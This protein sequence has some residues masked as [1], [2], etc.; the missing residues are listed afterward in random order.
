MRFFF[1][2]KKLCLSRVAV[3]KKNNNVDNMNIR[4]CNNNN[5]SDDNNNDGGSG[6]GGSDGGVVDNDALSGNDN[7][8]DDD[9]GDDTD[10]Q[11]HGDVHAR[12]QRS[13]NA[14]EILFPVEILRV[15]ADH[16]YRAGWTSTADTMLSLNKETKH[17]CE[18]MVIRQ[19]LHRRR[20]AV[21]R[22]LYRLFRFQLSMYAFGLG[23]NDRYHWELTAHEQ[24]MAKYEKSLRLDIP[25][26]EHAPL[27]A[28]LLWVSHPRESIGEGAAFVMPE[29]QVLK[30][31]R[32]L[33]FLDRCKYESETIR[34]D[35]CVATVLEHCAYWKDIVQKARCG[36]AGEETKESVKIDIR[37]CGLSYNPQS[38]MGIHRIS[39]F[40]RSIKLMNQTA[41]IPFANL[42][43]PNPPPPAAATTTS[44]ST[45]T[46]ADTLKSLSPLQPSSP[47]SKPGRASISND[48]REIP[49]IILVNIYNNP[50]NDI[51]YDI[52]APC[53]H[54]HANV[55]HKS[56]PPYWY[57]G[58]IPMYRLLDRMD[59]WKKANNVPL[60]AGY[61]KSIKTCIGPEMMM[62][63][64]AE[65][66]SHVHFRG[67][68]F[69]ELA[70]SRAPEYWPWDAPLLFEH[71]SLLCKVGLATDGSLAVQ[72]YVSLFV[73]PRD[74]ALLKETELGFWEPDPMIAHHRRHWH[75]RDLHHRAT[76]LIPPSPSLSSP[77][78]PSSSSS[79][80]PSRSRCTARLNETVAYPASLELVNFDMFSPPPWVSEPPKEDTIE[81]SV[82]YSMMCNYLEQHQD[83]CIGKDVR[84]C[85]F[86]EGLRS[87]APKH[88][89][90]P[91]ER[92]RD[93][94]S[95]PTPQMR[96]NEGRKKENRRR[97][98]NNELLPWMPRSKDV[99][100]SIRRAQTVIDQ[101]NVA[102]AIPSEAFPENPH[103]YMDFSSDSDSLGISDSGDNSDRD[104]E[105]DNNGD[106][107]GSSSRDCDEND[108]GDDI[109]DGGDDDNNNS[110]DAA[111]S[112]ANESRKCDASLEKEEEETADEISCATNGDSL[113]TDERDSSLTGDGN[114][115]TAVRKD[116][117]GRD[118]ST[119]GSVSDKDNDTVC[120]EYDDSIGDGGDSSCDG[121]DNDDDNDDYNDAK[122]NDANID[123]DINPDSDLD[124][125]MLCVCSE[126]EDE[127]EP[128]VTVFGIRRDIPLQPPERW[129]LS[130]SARQAMTASGNP[131][132]RIRK[133]KSTACIVSQ[134]R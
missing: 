42:P 131:Y 48:N 8:D 26:M 102:T 38:F 43:T 80:S 71:V 14:C 58:P 87:R 60:L 34:G 84:I 10:D 2:K 74:L 17:E 110:L 55:H 21:H 9:D 11:H 53:C 25:S 39:P 52:A 7:H 78:S 108:K 61:E 111:R 51:E 77:S 133:G 40:S 28:L 6:H 93:T 95:S 16:L 65:L 4:N 23:Y 50:Q 75:Y 120:H 90:K 57:V 105:G 98:K 35:E 82:Y 91:N 89:E 24:S 68:V 31:L 92:Y 36:V 81:F 54:E 106:S 127:I 116:D 125:E 32:D 114:I 5:N 45:T 130:E 126:S 62:Y 86:C 64:H 12:G 101:I 13:D 56:M 100:D 94:T 59:R 79:S 122:H 33:A 41:S 72:V 88:P 47:P 3:A 76:P 30:C 19:R 118:N 44:A 29:D 119:E 67:W 96:C 18:P 124:C 121:D 49:E 83:T 27:A 73:G 1:K 132:R 15:I 134:P 70:E 97:S 107:N 128:K 103:M 123:H 20:T 117:H 63:R 129:M 46:I 69:G 109:D 85:N 113:R 104:S 112:C 115:D 66:F 99:T 22:A 37:K